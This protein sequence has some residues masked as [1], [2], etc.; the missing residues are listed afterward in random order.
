MDMSYYH[1]HNFRA[2]LFV[3]HSDFVS[4]LFLRLIN[5]MSPCQVCV[6][7]VNTYFE[8]G[9]NLLQTCKDRD[10]SAT[11]QLLYQ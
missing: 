4:Q 1:I 7:L 9:Q 2:Y 6:P 3:L 5:L 8:P 10:S 11:L